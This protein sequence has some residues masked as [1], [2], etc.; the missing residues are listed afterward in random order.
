VQTLRIAPARTKLL[1]VVGEGY[2]AWLLSPNVAKAVPAE[3]IG[4]PK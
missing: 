4:L 2:N 3:R 1:E